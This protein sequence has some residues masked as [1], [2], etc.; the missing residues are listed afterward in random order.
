MNFISKIFEL[1]LYT[2]STDILFLLSISLKSSSSISL[3]DLF[4]SFFMPYNSFLILSLLYK[5]ISS[6]PFG[7]YSSN[8]PD[9]LDILLFKAL[10]SSLYKGIYLF[11]SKSSLK[12]SIVI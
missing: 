1:F 8:F 10:E 3:P 11:I 4:L 5:I 6:S 7:K 9:E 2:S 12:K